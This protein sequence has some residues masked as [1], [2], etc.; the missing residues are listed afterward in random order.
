ML[1]SN[2]QKPVFKIAPRKSQKQNTTKKTKILKIRIVFWLQFFQSRD[3]CLIQH[4]LQT[5]NANAKKTVQFQTF[6]KKEK[7]NFLTISIVLRFIPIN[8]ETFKPPSVQATGNQQRRGIQPLA[9]C[10]LKKKQ[11]LIFHPK[12]VTLWCNAYFQE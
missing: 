11:C 2:S 1:I 4:F 6:C 5:L 3:I 10:P 9:S 8:F 12:N 7:V